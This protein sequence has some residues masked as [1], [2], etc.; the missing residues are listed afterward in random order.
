[1]ARI[2]Y[3]VQNIVDEIRAQLDE[4]NVDSVS[5]ESDI[6][7]TINRAQDFAFDILATKYPEPILAYKFLPLVGNQAEYDIDNDV[8]ED[9]IQKIE[10]QIPSG[11]QQGFTAREVQRIS[12]RDVSNYESASRTNVPYYYAIYGRKIRFVPTPTGTYGC[13]VWFLRN[14]E[15]LVLPQGRITAPVDPTSSNYL[16][17]DDVGSSLVTET[18]QLGSYVNVVDGQNGEIKCSLQIQSIT[19]DRIG[20]RSVPTRT[21]VLGRTITGDLST[22]TIALDDYLA[23]IAGTCVPYFGRPVSNFIIQYAVAE[24]TRKLGGDA[25]TEEQVLEKFSKQVERVWTGRETTLRVKKRSQNWGVP[26]RRWYYE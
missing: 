3:T 17:V 22:T 20:F 2:L 26:T 6:L 15:E 24:I 10:M 12:Y 14:P 16:I 13:R 19:G 25:A 4:Q 11:S 8:F 21:E 18:D 5:T 7:P 9:R 1:M 23:P